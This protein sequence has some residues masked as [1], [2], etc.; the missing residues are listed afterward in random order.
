MKTLFQ[1]IFLTLCIA[2]V[3][4]SLYSNAQEQPHEERKV[5]RLVRDYYVTVGCGDW[6]SDESDQVK[7][8]EH[9]ID[10][11]KD[12]PHRFLGVTITDNTNNNPRDNKAEASY[13]RLKRS[14]KINVVADAR[15]ECANIIGFHFGPRSWIG[16]TIAVE[17]LW[18]ACDDPPGLPDDNSTV[19][20]ARES[21]EIARQNFD[22]HRGVESRKRQLVIQEL[23]DKILA[24][25]ATRLSKAE[26]ELATKKTYLDLFASSNRKLE[27]SLQKHTQEL[28]SLLDEFKRENSKTSTQ[29]SLEFDQIERELS[30]ADLKKTALLLDQLI[31]TQNKEAAWTASMSVRSA[32]LLGQF[33]VADSAYL[34]EIERLRP[35]L[36]QEHLS[37]AKSTETASSA[38]KQ[39]LA[40]CESRSA[41]FS[42]RVVSIARAIENRRQALIALESGLDSK[43][44]LNA[45]NEVT[46][47]EEFLKQVEKESAALW[48]PPLRSKSLNLPYFEEHYLRLRQ[49]AAYSLICELDPSQIR[50]ILRSGCALAA[51]ELP[52][53][54]SATRD[55]RD[56]LRN[57]LQSIRDLARPDLGPKVQSVERAIASE[58][59]L[60]AY[61]QFDD[62]LRAEKKS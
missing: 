52:K 41:E 59:W 12:V 43:K 7:K 40:A 36:T 49:Y 58:D 53:V 25:A 11:P 21:F 31:L 30:K 27:K 19:A 55:L 15:R 9:W 1:F 46:A 32:Q 13:D 8:E 23:K 51:R 4:P 26:I 34:D 56:Q 35:F 24:L 33:S 44:A 10:L 37:P 17:A 61:R 62:L 47:S 29:H 20:Q 48:A 22:C 3:H 50:P 28:A 6:G 14:V 54:K 5:V 57:S 2:D 38:L 45:S 60:E 42:N 16:V 18:N 39:V